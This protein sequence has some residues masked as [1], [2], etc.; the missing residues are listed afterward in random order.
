MT[1]KYLVLPHHVVL[2]PRDP[3]PPGHVLLRSLRR[4][5]LQRPAGLRHQHDG[6]RRWPRGLA[7]DLHTRGYCH[8]PCRP[9]LLL[10]SVRLPRDR[11]LPHRGGAR[12]RRVSSAVPGPECEL[13][14]RIGRPETAGCAGRGIQVEIRRS[15]VRGLAGLAEPLCVLECKQCSQAVPQ[16]SHAHLC[17]YDTCM[18]AADLWHIHLCRSSAPSTGSV[19]SSPPSS[20]TWATPPARRSC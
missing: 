15:G 20:R 14:L 13:G 8:G 18:F 12:L 5:R 2:P 6:R 11:R 7:V 10:A 17:I 4:G 3:V 1:D 16:K 9:S 19:S